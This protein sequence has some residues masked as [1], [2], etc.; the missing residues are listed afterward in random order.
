MIKFLLLCSILFSQYS[1]SQSVAERTVDSIGN[2]TIV[3]TIDTLSEGKQSCYING[4]ICTWENKYY[5][6]F[7]VY[8]IPPKDFYLTNKDKFLVRFSDGE[9]EELE[10]F[11]EGALLSDNTLSDIKVLIAEETLRKMTDYAV[12]YIGLL[13]PTF[14]HTIPIDVDYRHKLFDLSYYMLNFNV[15]KADNVKTTEIN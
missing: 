15:D 4:M 6:G 10:I 5:Y 1:F 14:K 3:T 9:V 2:V 13:T 11:T 7:D 12:T 8:L